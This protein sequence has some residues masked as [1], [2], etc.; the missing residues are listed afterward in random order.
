MIGVVIYNCYL[1]VCWLDLKIEEF[2][3]CEW[4][5]SYVI[6]CVDDERLI[7]VLDYFGDNLGL[8]WS[9][10]FGGGGIVE[11][12]KVDWYEDWWVYGGFYI[13]VIWGWFILFKWIVVFVCV[14][15]FFFMF[16]NCLSMK[17]WSGYDII[18]WFNVL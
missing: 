4:D 17:G 14:L 7:D 18:F 3:N 10:D 16:V 1:N 2:C 9:M 12:K 15:S 5:C 6:F 11:L 13:F 8:Y